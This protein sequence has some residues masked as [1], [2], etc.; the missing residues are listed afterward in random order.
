MSIDSL[1]DGEGPSYVQNFSLIIKNY[2]SF[3][4]VMFPWYFMILWPYIGICTFDKVGTSSSLYRLFLGG[5]TLHQSTS[6]EILGDVGRWACCW[7]PWV[8][9]S[10]AWVIRWAGLVLGCIATSLV[11]KFTGV[12]LEPGFTGVG[13]VIESVVIGLRTG[14]ACTG[15]NL[16]S[17]WAKQVP[18]FW[19]GPSVW[20][21]EGSSGTMMHQ[22][23]GSTGAGLKATGTFLMLG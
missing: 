12:G 8:G 23:P 15:L 21:H 6:L 14:S 7:P 2:Y 18:V 5:K 17:S 4:G 10:G 1:I 19:D 20:F 11:P 16:G 13:L 22:E 9:R 3:G